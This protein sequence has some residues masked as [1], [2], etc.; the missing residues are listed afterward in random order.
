MLRVEGLHAG[1]GSLPVLRG[2][3]LEVRSGEAVAVI[4]PN[5]AGKST[6]LRTIVGLVRALSGRIECDGVALRRLRACQMPQLGIVYVPAE[7]EL[8]PGM[9]VIENLQLGAYR[10]LASAGRQLA[11][12]FELFPRLAERRHQ[13]AGTLSGGEQQMLA[14]GRALMC[15]PKLLLLDEPSTG[16][17]PKTVAE[18]YRQLSRLKA[19]GLT[20]LLAEQQVSLAL[21]LTERAYVL[22]HGAIRMSGKSGDL[23]GDPAIKTAYLGVA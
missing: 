21:S 20:I 14:I 1:Y 9:A 4:G 17:A 10:N 18:L 16:L 5:G 8:F 13:L 3:D 23:L 7:K 12:V 22:E 15:A 19:E 2:I 11:Y 6:L